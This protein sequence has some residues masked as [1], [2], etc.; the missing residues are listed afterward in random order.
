MSV[1]LMT[2][3]F[4]EALILIRPRPEEPR[5]P[6]PPLFL[7]KSRG[8][9][10]RPLPSSKN[11]HFQNE[12]RCTTFLV[13]MIFICMRIRLSTCPRF[14]TEARGNSKMAYLI[15]RFGNF[16]FQSPT[17][18]PPPPPPGAPLTSSSESATEL[19]PIIIFV[20]HGIHTSAK[21]KGPQCSSS[22]E[23][24][25]RYLLYSGT[26]WVTVSLGPGLTVSAQISTL[27][28]IPPKTS[29]LYLKVWLFV[30]LPMSVCFPSMV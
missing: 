5:G 22:R 29:K 16:F 17:P 2:T 8:W 23:L 26:W 9:G 4:Y 19:V 3:L 14:E 7:D 15:L 25:N 28:C 20:A 10:N 18:P 30:S 1:I 27:Y 13:K 24:K 11:T 21:H 12:A 6:R